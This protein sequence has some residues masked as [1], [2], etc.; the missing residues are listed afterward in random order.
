MPPLHNR[1][2]RLS[3]RSWRRNP[4]KLFQIPVLRHWKSLPFSYQP[5]CCRLEVNTCYSSWIDSTPLPIFNFFS[6]IVV[7][8]FSK[9]LKSV[10]TWDT[11]IIQANASGLI[12]K[13]ILGLRSISASFSAFWHWLI[14]QNKWQK[15][16]KLTGTGRLYFCFDIWLFDSMYCERKQ[17]CIRELTLSAKI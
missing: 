7:F 11:L 14:F 16:D 17:W 4:S 13:L 3:T 12:W 1:C 9:S 10:F 15:S 8:M 5:F 2:C 6:N